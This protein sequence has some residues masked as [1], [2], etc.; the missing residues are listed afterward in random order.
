MNNP[1]DFTQQAQ[2]FYTRSIADQVQ[3]IQRVYDLMMRFGRGEL[4]TKELY[5]EYIKFA[6][7]ETSRYASDLA[8]L[9]LNYFNEWLALNKRYNSLFLDTFSPAKSE[10]AAEVVAREV[11]EPK[12]VEMALHAPLGKEAVQS[13]VLENKRG[14]TADISFGVSEFT[15]PGEATPVRLPIQVQPDHFSLEPGQEKTVTLRLPLTEDLLEANQRHEGTIY[16]HGYDDLEVKLAV[17][18][19]EVDKDQ[20]DS[21]AVQATEK[22]KPEKRPSSRKP[23]ADK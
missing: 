13:F 8:M 6:S 10:P 11:N 4:S 15:C 9:G 22:K 20:P 14:G 5:D 17:W 21:P 12:R 23:A 16:I 19:D 7:Q 1:K 3:T 18:A 2:D